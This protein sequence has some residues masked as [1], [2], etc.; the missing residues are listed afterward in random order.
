V[1]SSAGGSGEGTVAL[2]IFIVLSLFFFITAEVL[3]LS[4]SLLSQAWSSLSVRLASRREWGRFS[5]VGRAGGKFSLVVGREEG[6][7]SLAG[8]A[9]AGAFPLAVDFL[10]VQAPRTLIA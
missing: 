10:A 7:F 8:R 5:L 1:T 6:T 9:E 2:F 3:F 4:L